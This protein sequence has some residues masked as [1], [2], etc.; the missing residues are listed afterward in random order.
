MNAITN[1]NDT[2][3][4]SQ[5]VPMP[6]DLAEVFDSQAVNPLSADNLAA[7]PKQPVAEPSAILDR[8]ALTRAAYVVKAVVEKRCT[9]PVLQ[10]AR[11]FEQDGALV[12]RGT[13]LDMQVDVTLPASIDS[14]F[15]T[16]MPAHNLHALL[17]KARKSDH[18]GLKLSAVF[19]E[20]AWRNNEKVPVDA[21]TCELDTEHTTYNLQTIM[22]CDFP[23]LS[24]PV[25]PVRFSLNGD[26]LWTIFDKVKG[27]ISLEETR[28]YLNGVY[29]HKTDDG[30]RAVAT[31][32]HRLY[33]HDMKLQ[34][35]DDFAG[36]IIPRKMI[37][38]FLS[39]TRTAKHRPGRVHIEVTDSKVAFT[40]DNVRMVSKLIDGN[41]P[42]YQRVFPCSNDKL[43][44]FDSDGVAAAINDVALIR[45]DRGRA[46]A[47]EIE[48][49]MAEVSVN[50]PDAGNARAS[51][52]IEHTGNTEPLRIGFNSI[53]FTEAL[54][55][56]DGEVTAELAD[57][58]TPIKIT[59]NDWFQAV[60]MP[61]RL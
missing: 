9:I 28:Y 53:Y 52:Y 48:D 59:G 47:L 22:P 30:F 13:D 4:L 56:F 44:K 50:N 51:F 12:V 1:W 60:I 15:D 43:V 35:I 57:P 31:D 39:L 55:L 61:M 18:A 37:T 27:A 38:T 49:G 42:D 17:S 33:A 25:N 36:V 54:A 24:E 8:E 20:E 7:G 19:T 3:A 41:F 32:G 2:T 29:L 5:P 23:D 58:G 34:D 40:F 14:G 21:R 10:N 16:T 26:D 11:L 6:P 46:F 45:S